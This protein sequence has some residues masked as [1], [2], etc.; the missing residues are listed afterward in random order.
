MSDER[1]R[2][3]RTEGRVVPVPRAGWQSVLR[4]GVEPAERLLYRGAV[5]SHN[6][7]RRS[8]PDGARRHHRRRARPA[9]E[10]AGGQEPRRALSRRVTGALDGRASRSAVP[11]LLAL[12]L[13]GCRGGDEQRAVASKGDPDRGRA[14]FA[15]AGGCGCH[16]PEK[17]PVGA[18]GVEI[19]TPFGTFYSSNVTSDAEAG[20]GAWSDL[21]IARAIRGGNLR[22]GS[23]EAPVMPY[24]EYAGMADDDLRDL[25]AYL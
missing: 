17:G 25:I 20:I 1:H 4:H 19:K 10:D 6:G 9:A 5:R 3:R 11:L 7:A 21:E 24:E 23:V 15:L 18:G 8:Q 22:D 12:T 13:A 16:T 14:V 2:I